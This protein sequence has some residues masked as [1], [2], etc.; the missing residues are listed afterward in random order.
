[1]ANRKWIRIRWAGVYCLFFLIV[2]VAGLFWLFPADIFKE[3]ASARVADLNPACSLFIKDVA[4]EFPLGL[5]LEKAELRFNHLAESSLEADSIRIYPNVG[6]LFDGRTELDLDIRGYGGRAS[7]TVGYAGI[8][9]PQVPSRAEVKFEN[10]ATQNVAYL[11]HVLGRQVFGKL[12]GSIS[13]ARKNKETAGAGRLDFNIQN[14]SYPLQGKIMGIDKL[15]FTQIEGQLV[16]A[17]K[18]IKIEFINING[19]KI[20]CTVKGEVTIDPADFRNSQINM[21][22]NLELKAMNNQKVVFAVTGTLMNPVTK[23]G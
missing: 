8:L 16:M 23:V 21:T 14:G 18:S 3:V 15:E 5:R 4:P 13:F 11:K 9:S 12:K 17:E 22:G 10:M 2:F 7:G 6:K 19:E 1:M 20:R